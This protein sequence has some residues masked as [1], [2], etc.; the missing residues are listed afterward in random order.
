MAKFTTYITV[1]KLFDVILDTID[2]Q[3]MIFN[4]YIPV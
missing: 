4:E 3:K 2:D 1:K